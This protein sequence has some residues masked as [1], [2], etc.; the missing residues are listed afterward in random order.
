MQARVE[1]ANLILLLLLIQY[2]CQYY[3]YSTV[4]YIHHLREGPMTTNSRPTTSP[5][6][7]LIGWE[8][9]LVKSTNTK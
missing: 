2:Y 8:R 6:L 5:L 1:Q 4:L 7:I 3:L 9:D